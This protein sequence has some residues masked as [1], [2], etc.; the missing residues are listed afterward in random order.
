MNIAKK[1]KVLLLP[2]TR[3]WAFDNIANAIIRYNPYPDKILY[4]KMFICDRP[5]INYKD[6]DYVY[7]MFEAEQS[8]PINK[9]KMIRGC[10]SA[11][12]LEHPNY[13]PK[14][15]GDMFSRC[16]AAVFV[17][18][19]LANTISP[20]LAPDINWTIIRDASDEAVFYP[21]ENQKQEAFSAIFVG[22]TERRIKNFPAIQRICSDAGV[23]L[24]VARDIP[25]H[26]LVY[27][28]AKAD[29]CINFSTAE[30]GPQTFL[31]A[32][33][34]GVPMLIRSTNDL[35][36]KIPCFTGETEA[37]FVSILQNLKTH[38]DLCVQVGQEARKIV[39]GE[40]TYKKVAA[41]FADFFLRLGWHKPQ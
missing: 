39:L 30:G 1:M 14:S 7:V 3:G 8:I 20:F 41:R 18:E 21:I 26:R 37:D 22:K 38:R 2:D 28:Y 11:F 25:R 9:E 32:G 29:V 10:Y 27:E 13:S 5:K 12:W 19:T 6:W 33:L 4:T 16:R 31:E 36:K 35:S 23:K 24:M 40:F 34:C 15:L 17:N